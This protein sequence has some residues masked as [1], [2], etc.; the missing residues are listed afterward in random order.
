[1]ANEAYLFLPLPARGRP[2]TGGR[3]TCARALARPSRLWQ[4]FIFGVGIKWPHQT[5]EKMEKEENDGIGEV[6]TDDD[7]INLTPAY[8]YEYDVCGMPRDSDVVSLH[9]SDMEGLA[10]H[11]PVMV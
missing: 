2:R 3:A 9:P 1:M 10:G 5:S 7:G 4:P 6:S 8:E 11:Y